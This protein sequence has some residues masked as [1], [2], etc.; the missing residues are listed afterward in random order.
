MSR[1]WRGVLAVENEQTGDGRIFAPG[2]LV[3]ADLPLPLALLAGDQHGNP[4][5]GPVV[6]NI[7]RIER[8]GDDVMGWGVIDDSVPEAADALRRLSEGTAPFGQ[9]WGLSIDGDDWQVQVVMTDPAEAEALDDVLLLASGAG[10]YRPGVLIA[11][12]G[13][14]DVEPAP[15]QV[16]MEDASG[17]II[18]R[19]THLRIR[20][21][22]MC[23]VPAFAG[24][25]LELDPDAGLT[26][27]PE[28]E[29][30]LAAGTTP[31]PP[32]PSAWFRF[33][34]NDVPEADWVDQGGGLAA[35][36]L[37]VT[38][39]GQVY[40][41]LAVWGSCHIGY[42]GECVTAPPSPS[43]YAQFHQGVVDTDEGPVNVGQLVVGCDHA[44]ARLFAQGARDHYAHVAMAWA[45]V[46]VTDGEFGPWVAGAARPGLTPEQVRVVRAAGI[47][48]DWR[49]FDG[50]L[51]LVGIQSVSVRGFPV[52]REDSHALAASGTLPAVAMPAPV[53]RMDDDGHV[54]TLIAAGMVARCS[55]CEARAREARADGPGDL[56]VLAASLLS[57]MRRTDRRLAHMDEAIAASAS[58]RVK[59]ALAD[60]A[61][62]LGPPPAVAA[63]GRVREAARSRQ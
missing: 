20:G 9:R 21:V 57:F 17:A 24:A 50:A 27:D 33:S 49:A 59:A 19:V 28:P 37:T 30:V 41:H 15:A 43:S 55:D 40:G 2:S 4:D 32:P 8:Q 60:V 1:R 6:G 31:A 48:G 36:P 44:D 51:D 11:A 45:D 26:E 29:V 18:E 16:L 61:E 56:A 52:R 42:P 62:V 14:P 39:D 53:V 38:D 23:A 13:D 22:T 5:A 12:A 25:Y 47:S 7:D 54:V 34:E 35:V 46:R 3:W 10:R 63:A 58:A